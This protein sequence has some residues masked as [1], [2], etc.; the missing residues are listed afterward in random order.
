[1]YY[2]NKL[3][4]SV[5]SFPDLSI[6]ARLF[7]YIFALRN[8]IGIFTIDQTLPSGGREIL[9]RSSWVHSTRQRDLKLQ[10]A[11]RRGEAEQVTRRLRMLVLLQ[12]TWVWYLLQMSGS[13]KLPVITVPGVLI[14]SF[15]LRGHQALICA[16]QHRHRQTDTHTHIHRYT[17]THK[18][19]V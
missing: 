8:T 5:P 17:C 4:N 3:P 12:R 13:S 14:I 18:Y 6:S 1:M 16:Y 9:V 11:G 10:E 2:H 15:G 19:T 7:V